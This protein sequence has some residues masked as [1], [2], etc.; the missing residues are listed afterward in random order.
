[1]VQKSKGRK[2]SRSVVAGEKKKNEMKHQRKKNYKKK[3][4]KKIQCC[5]CME[6]I[7]DTADNTITCGKVNHALCGECKLKCG[8]CPMCRSHKV[9]KPIS[10]NVNL[11]MLQKNQV[12]CLKKER[13]LVK[14]LSAENKDYGNGIY[15]K[16]DEDYRGNGIYLHEDYDDIYIY[17]SYDNRWVLDDDYNPGI[18]YIFGETERG[19]DLFGNHTWELSGNK[20]WVT[21]MVRIKQI[22]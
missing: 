8:D 5:V 14:G 15:E 20:G 6:D 12:K 11:R 13:I 17:H 18:Y 1:M 2:K 3:V 10:Q 9:Q 21:T 16:I 19:C 22:K 4:V 7:P